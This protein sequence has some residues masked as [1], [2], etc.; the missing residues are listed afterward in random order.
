MLDIKGKKRVFS[1]S[2]GKEKSG[3][4]LALFPRSLREGKK[5]EFR[6]FSLG[7]ENVALIERIYFLPSKV[8]G[9]RKAGYALP[10]VLPSPFSD[11][12][13]ISKSQKEDS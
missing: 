4:R 13:L 5:R 12:G 2:L 7:R 9:E 8:R 10:A 11:K 6:L 3:T 1:L